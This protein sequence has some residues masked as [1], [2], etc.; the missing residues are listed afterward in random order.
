MNE[1]W[2]NATLFLNATLWH[3]VGPL[4]A[5]GANVS[6]EGHVAS[7]GPRVTGTCHHGESE[8]DG[9]HRDGNAGNNGVESDAEAHPEGQAVTWISRCH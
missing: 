6:E 4:H 2:V 3:A 8:N 5:S 7:E 1:P 9:A